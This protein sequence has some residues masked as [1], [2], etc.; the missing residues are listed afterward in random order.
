MFKENFVTVFFVWLYCY[1]HFTSNKFIMKSISVKDTYIWLWFLYQLFIIIRVYNMCFN[2]HC[3]IFWCQN[4]NLNDIHTCRANFLLIYVQL[5]KKYI[6]KGYIFC[7][8]FMPWFHF[9]VSL[10]IF[11]TLDICGNCFVSLYSFSNYL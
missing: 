4:I 1:I 9:F 8:Y 10:F 3:N 11:F 2:I 6:I 7:N 5:L